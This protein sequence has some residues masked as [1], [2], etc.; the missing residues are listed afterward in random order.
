MGL[1]ARYL[2]P[3]WQ[4]RAVLSITTGIRPYHGL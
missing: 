3:L 1:C 4:S 2:L